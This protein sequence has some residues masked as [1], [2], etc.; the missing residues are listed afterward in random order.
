[1]ALT[2]HLGDWA[3]QTARSST[4]TGL[5]WPP[6]AYAHR[7]LPPTAP[8]Q[9]RQLRILAWRFLQRVQVLLDTAPLSLQPFADRAA[10]IGAGG[11]TAV[12]NVLGNGAA[13]V[14]KRHM[15]SS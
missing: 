6:R 14:S 8:L 11:G 4:A 2:R 10:L 15:N 7:R 9:A 13:F 12:G 1:M 5:R 3:G